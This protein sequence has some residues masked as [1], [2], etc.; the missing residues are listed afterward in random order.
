MKFE[1]FRAGA[2]GFVC[3]EIKG[4]TKSIVFPL[5]PSPKILFS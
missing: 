3:E 2:Y 5:K 1:T 4:H